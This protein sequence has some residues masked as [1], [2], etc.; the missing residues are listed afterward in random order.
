MGA[1][2]EICIVFIDIVL[3]KNLQNTTIDI[4]NFL[5]VSFIYN[6]KEKGRPPTVE[7]R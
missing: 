5:M 2:S 1:P 4:K 6:K 3:P 7:R